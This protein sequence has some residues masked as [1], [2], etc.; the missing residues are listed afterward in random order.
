MMGSNWSVGTPWAPSYEIASNDDGCGTPG[1][2]ALLSLRFLCPSDPSQFRIP[3]THTALLGCFFNNSCAGVPL[4]RHRSRGCAPSPPAPPL[5][6]T[7]ALPANCPGYF[8]SNRTCM[9]ADGTPAASQESCVCPLLLSPGYSYSIQTECGGFGPQGDT[10]LALYDDDNPLR[11]VAVNDDDR[12][13]CPGNV[14]AS[15]VNY[16]VPCTSHGRFSLHESCFSTR[17]CNA[18]VVTGWQVGAA[19]PTVNCGAQPA[20]TSTSDYLPD[21]GDPGA[22]RR[23]SRRRVD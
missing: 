9:S 12:A 6:P 20:V 1:G 8:M 10:Y 11:P 5:A 4:V 22:G 23:F 18:S 19:Q 17:T 2:G 14:F 21:S 7:P 16:T 15:R 3:Q 13:A